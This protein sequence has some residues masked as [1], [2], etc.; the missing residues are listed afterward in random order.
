MSNDEIPEGMERCLYGENQG[1][2]KK[3]GLVVNMLRILM[4]ISKLP[5]DMSV[6]VF[7]D[8]IRLSHPFWPIT[9]DVKAKKV[10]FDW[11]MMGGCFDIHCL[12]YNGCEKSKVSGL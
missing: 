11:M 2:G 6:L 1:P 8:D 9:R 3:I 12:H 5:D 10:Q 4:F 7:Q